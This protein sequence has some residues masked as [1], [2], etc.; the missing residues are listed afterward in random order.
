VDALGFGLL[1][2]LAAMVFGQA[3]GFSFVPYDDPVM[4]T[5]NGYVRGG[6]AELCFLDGKNSLP[7]IPASGNACGYGT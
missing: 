1:A 4:V 2:I 7:A 3:L 5:G 6:E